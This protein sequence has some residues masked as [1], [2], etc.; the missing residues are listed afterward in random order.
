M[1]TPRGREIEEQRT[2][3]TL[4]AREHTIDPPPTRQ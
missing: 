3:E 2:R 1:D 4:E